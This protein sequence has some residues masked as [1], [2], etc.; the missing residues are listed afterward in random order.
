[1]AGINEHSVD[2]SF[3][4]ALEFVHAAT[5]K[6]P[7]SPTFYEAMKS[8]ERDQWLAAC[9]DEIRAHTEN[10][11]WQWA[12]LPDGVSP[13]GS[14]FV[15]KIK[16]TE[17]G[18][19]ERF[20]ARLVAQGFSQRPGWDF[21]ENFAPTIRLSVV[22]AI[23]ALVAAEDMECDSL[24]IT[25]AFLNADLDETIYMK[26][27]PGYE[28]YSP[29]GKKLYCLLLKAIYGLKQG[30]R[31]WYLKLS[32]VMLQIGFK[33]VPSEP[34]LFVW[35]RP[36][37]RVVVPTYV[38][39]MH[40]A[41]SNT[42][43]VATVKKELGQHFKLRDLGPTKWFL[44]IH[45]T[46]DRPNRSLSISQRQY[47]IDM[48]ED[49]NMADCH[50]VST[51]M[52]PGL[53]LTHDMCPQSPEEVEEMKLVPYG[54]AVG[55]LNWLALAT[56]PDISY[57]VSQLARFSSNPGPQHWQAVKRLLRYI[58]GTVD[59]KLTYGPS[60]HPTKFQTFS[61]ADYA[62]DID[63]AKSTG[64]YVVMMGGAAVAWSS[65]LQTRV[66]RST[67]ESEYMAAEAASREMA[68]FRF[69][70]ADLGFPVTLP[71]PLAMDNQSAIA[72]A[73]NP[74]HQGRMKHIN[75]I[76][77]ALRESVEHG[78]V[79]PYFIPTHEMTA[80]IFTKALDRSKVQNCVK[81]LGLHD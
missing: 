18:S 24:D 40:I 49:F 80:D 67:T 62:G 50:P 27:P 23:F 19:V 69:I 13:V 60:P 37:D 16:R 36:G 28:Q 34:C 77:H 54:R 30:S 17:D 70:F 51:P 44:G 10:G 8:P 31:Q 6:D 45:I 72:A 29:E 79:S 55:K 42:D 22:R 12:E 39:D 78:E 74:E 15:L 1:M 65:K 63:S 25:T 41:S 73:K 71:L 32:E 33:K 11:T 3:E 48:L 56:R 2:F 58:K 9:L 59:F 43:G 26:P 81:L 76:Y 61:D 35:E 38:D 20:K 75:P 5:A 68:F 7:D 64:G 57:T 46:R 4:Q 53:R 47:C 14:R 21:F 52:A 66:A